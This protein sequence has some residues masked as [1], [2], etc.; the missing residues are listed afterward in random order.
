MH[1]DTTEE[2]RKHRTKAWMRTNQTPSSRLGINNI[3]EKIFSLPAFSSLLP[4]R[5]FLIRLLSVCN[6]CFLDFRTWTIFQP[7][8]HAPTRHCDTP[9]GYKPNRNNHLVH[10][11]QPATLSLHRAQFNPTGPDTVSVALPNDETNY[12][13][14]NRRL[15]TPEDRGRGWAIVRRRSR[16]NSLMRR[17]AS[18]ADGHGKSHCF[19]S[20]A[21]PPDH[22]DDGKRG[23]SGAQGDEGHALRHRGDRGLGDRVRLMLPIAVN[24]CTYISHRASISANHPPPS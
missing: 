22:D 8:R 2:G 14:H 5:V 1:D 18:A 6:P 13:N 10:L 11:F 21:A 19:L 9:G 7:I 12:A 3:T 17:C 20:L 4:P 16:C 24:R 23:P 15:T